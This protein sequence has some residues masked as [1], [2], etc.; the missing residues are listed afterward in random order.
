MS[1]RSTD[2]L[3]GYEAFVRKAVARRGAF[4]FLVVATIILALG[5]AI[6]AR[7]VD[8][9]DFHSYGDALWWSLQTVTT[10]GYGDIVPN[11]TIGRAIGA[12]VMVLGITF[13]PFL[14]ATVTSLFISEDA[15]DT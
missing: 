5:A 7:L 3:Q 13:L 1:V 15:A 2:R 11:N 8:P 10:V 6:L 4:P 12:F 9:D 14:T